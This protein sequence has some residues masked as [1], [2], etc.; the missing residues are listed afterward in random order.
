MIQRESIRIKIS[1]KS[2]IISN[3]NKQP[4]GDNMI[5]ILEKAAWE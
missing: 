1:L 2:F 5:W 3:E 4:C